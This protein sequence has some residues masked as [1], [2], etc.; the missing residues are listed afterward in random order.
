MEYIEQK[1]ID[2]TI[3]HKQNQRVQLLFCAIY[4]N[5]NTFKDQNKTVIY[6]HQIFY[7][8]SIK[9]FKEI[10]KIKEEARPIIA[11]YPPEEIQRFI[12]IDSVNITKQLLAIYDDSIKSLIEEIADIYKLPVYD[13]L[14]EVIA[15]IETVNNLLSTYKD[16][17][18]AERIK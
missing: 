17:R 18:L 2:F 10:F 12:E 16:K 11:E 1:E 14:K 15:R 4:A 13:I 9:I 8:K 3:I 7:K 5:F 6:T